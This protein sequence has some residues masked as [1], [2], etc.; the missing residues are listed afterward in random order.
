MTWAEYTD[1]TVSAPITNYFIYAYMRHQRLT[2]LK[3]IRSNS[4]FDEICLRYSLRKNDII[5]NKLCIFPDSY[6]VLW[7]ETEVRYI[8]FGSYKYFPIRKHDRA[9]GGSNQ[10][11]I[12]FDDTECNIHHQLVTRDILW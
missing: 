5:T 9:C 7:C 2:V 12:D 3:I 10:V 4:E 1:K 11:Y 6:A 8:G